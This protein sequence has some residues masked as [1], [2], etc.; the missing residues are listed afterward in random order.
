MD[1]Q[2]PSF[3]QLLGVQALLSA[4]QGKG[5]GQQGGGQKTPQAGMLDSIF[6]PQGQQ[7]HK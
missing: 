2:T 4:R 5:A 3:D 7:R 1:L 6:S